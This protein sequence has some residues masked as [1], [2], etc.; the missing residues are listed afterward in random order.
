MEL[1]APRAVSNRLLPAFD[2]V[3]RSIFGAVPGN[4]G[5][6]SG[7]P[8]V[9]S[10]VGG[11][12]MAGVKIGRL[13]VDRIGEPAEGPSRKVT[14]GRRSPGTLDIQSMRVTPPA[15]FPVILAGASRFGGR[16]TSASRSRH[17]TTRGSR[18]PVRWWKAEQ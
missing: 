3:V 10:I 7:S 2:V 6:M 5:H 16:P 12:S 8:A 1:G 11:L 4:R 17:L 18:G 15:E 14:T 9:R 13:V